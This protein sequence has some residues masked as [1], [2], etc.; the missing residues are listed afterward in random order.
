MPFAVSGVAP[1]ANREHEQKLAFFAVPAL[2]TEQVTQ[3]AD[4]RLQLQKMVPDK[5]IGLLFDT[6]QL[7]AGQW[8]ALHLQLSDDSYRGR[9]QWLLSDD[10]QDWRAGGQHELLK[11]ASGPGQTTLNLAGQRAR[12]LRL[13]WLDK[14]FHLQRASLHWRELR[15]ADAALRWSNWQRATPGRQSGEYLFDLG[16]RAPFERLEIRLPQVNTVVLAHWYSR[17]SAQVPWQALAQGKLSQLGQASLRVEGFG[18][19][20]KRYWRLVVDT[21]QGGLG[22]GMPELRAAWQPEQITFVARGG[23]P[24]WLAYGY[25]KAGAAPQTL[26]ELLDGSTVQIASATLAAALPLQARASVTRVVTDSDRWRKVGLW[27]SLLL[28]VLLL[29]AMAWK[30]LREPPLPDGDVRN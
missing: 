2:T 13:D 20:P 22:K 28:A 4:G 23:G 3:D 16:Q 15:H 24:F 7:P 27:A 1:A 19:V 14:P 29:G 10:L 21:R 30:L 26:G 17:D 12:Y 25:E 8:Q 11:L 6:S 9:V 18:S 5:P